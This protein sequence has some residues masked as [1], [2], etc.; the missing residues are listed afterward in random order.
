MKEALAETR[1][2]DVLN[3]ISYS[4]LN[5]FIQKTPLSAQISL[6]KSFAQYFKKIEEKEVEVKHDAPEALEQENF[7]IENLKAI[8]VENH[9]EID[10]LKKDKKELE[11]KL[12]N[13]K[14]NLKRIDN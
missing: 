3:Y 1:F 13:L 7:I 8:I 4:Q 2:D 14:E 9:T 10:E 6:K 11:A 5:F 12:K